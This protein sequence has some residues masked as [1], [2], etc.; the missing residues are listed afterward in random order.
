MG[1]T[2]E[3]RVEDPTAKAAVRVPLTAVLQ[4][5]EQAQVWVSTGGR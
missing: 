1:E 4:A 2:A 5:N 3:L